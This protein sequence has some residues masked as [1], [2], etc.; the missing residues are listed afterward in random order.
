MAARRTPVDNPAPIAVA[1][2][3]VYTS[4]RPAH[5]KN[6]SM[7][8]PHR[9]R[10]ARRAALAMLALFTAVATVGCARPRPTADPPPITGDADTATRPPQGRAQD[11]VVASADA[12]TLPDSGARYRTID[13][14]CRRIDLAPVTDRFPA[15]EHGATSHDDNPTFADTHCS[16]SATTTRTADDG[17]IIGIDATVW[18]SADAAAG[19]QRRDRVRH[20]DSLTEVPGLGTDAFVYDDDLLGT[21]VTVY[22]GDLTLMITCVATFGVKGDPADLT[23]QL[24][25]LA[26]E[27]L[28]VLRRP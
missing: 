7:G 10:F 11:A 2:F 8:T 17:A 28:P 21:V 20:G 1:R 18:H 6:T 14:I 4:L 16:F 9:S 24:V 15:V 25:A 3:A 5:G 22:D 26:R 27:S 23:D 13:N 12:T 19:I